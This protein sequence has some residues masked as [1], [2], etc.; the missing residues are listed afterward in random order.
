MRTGIVFCVLVVLL[1]VA[2]PVESQLTCG[3]P[4][5]T[6][7]AMPLTDEDGASVQYEDL[8][9]GWFTTPGAPLNIVTCPDGAFQCLWVPK[10]ITSQ[11]CATT[12]LDLGTCGLASSDGRK[13]C[14]VTD[15]FSQVGM[16]LALATDHASA[17]HFGMWF[18]TLDVIRGPNDPADPKSSHRLP[19]WVESIDF[20]ATPTKITPTSADDASDATARIIIALYTAANTG[21]PFVT[22]AARQ[23][24]RQAADELAAAFVT[25]DFARRPISVRGR[26]ATYWLASGWHTVSGNPNVICSDTVPCQDFAYAGY[27]GDA[28]IALLAAYVSTAR[29]LYLNVATDAIET[30]LYAAK[31]Q[32]GHFAV[33]PVVFAWYSPDG[34]GP[35]A[36]R[37]RRNC[38]ANP[39]DWT[40]DE[41]DAPRAVSLCKA[42]YFQRLAGV[43]MDAALTSYCNDWVATGALSYKVT[44]VT[45]TKVFT[46]TGVPTE[47]SGVIDSYLNNGLG[48]YLNFFCG[49]DDLGNRLAAII[50]NKYHLSTHRF[51]SESCFGVYDQTFTLVSIGSAIGRDSGAYTP[52]TSTPRQL[53]ASGGTASVK[54]SWSGGSG[55]DHYEVWRRND[56]LGWGRVGD[57]FTTSYVDNAVAD[58]TS[59]LYKVR[60][61]TSSAIPTAFSNVDIATVFT[62]ADDPLVPGSTRIKA[63][64]VTELRSA[65]GAVY[66]T[67]RLPAPTYSRPIVQFQTIVSAVDFVELR[68]ALA[69]ALAALAIPVMAYSQPNLRSGLTV[70]AADVTEL[71]GNTR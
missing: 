8:V 60:G 63:V 28:A 12:D 35:P 31:W 37:C 1:V 69:E 20:T 11:S 46:S 40:W 48:A 15:Q 22:D 67:A 18:N 71:R 68:D 51:N 36:V 23:N 50:R 64:H 30:Y 24:Y 33:P 21:N 49:T 47:S 3:S 39:G 32:A 55:I 5:I 19:A 9:A 14:Q 59:Y 53:S 41:A 66:S 43:T 38:G 57:V 42:A 56:S 27:F 6:P 2:L 4:S 70:R 7:P 26:T 65:I 34:N 61:M 17:D 54:L 58:G 13:S 29:A 62:F 44:P 16:G 25:F 52:Q 45:Y 10:F